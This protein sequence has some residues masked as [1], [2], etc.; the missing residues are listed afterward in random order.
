MTKKIQPAPIF[1]RVPVTD[2]GGDGRC[3][4]LQAVVEEITPDI[5][6]QPP[7]YRT[8]RLDEIQSAAAHIHY[9]EG[10]PHTCPTAELDADSSGTLNTTET[11]SAYGAIVADTLR[12][13]WIPVTPTFPWL[14]P[15]GLLPLPSRWHISIG[16]PLRELEG[17]ESGEVGPRCR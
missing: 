7:H 2:D 3:L 13:P 5:H 4:I 11:A 9:S 10:A 16:E 15:L 6:R 14:G 17:L 8:P 1:F 12:I